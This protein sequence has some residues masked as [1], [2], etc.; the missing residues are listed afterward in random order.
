MKRMG[1]FLGIFFVFALFFSALLQV[2]GVPQWLNMIILVL[3]AGIL[4]LLFLML[5][6]KLDK[7]KEE[8]ESKKTKEFD[9]FA[10]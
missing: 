6:A 10:D 9:P 4:Y 1:W 8:E 3:T 2:V 5:C 7:K